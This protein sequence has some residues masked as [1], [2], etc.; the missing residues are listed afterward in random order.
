M[1]LKRDDR[2]TPR[3][4]AAMKEIGE[5]LLR[6]ADEIEGSTGLMNINLKLRFKQKG[7]PLQIVFNSE[8]EHKCPD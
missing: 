8:S 6:H 4:D 5:E 7:E 1:P 3:I 2:P